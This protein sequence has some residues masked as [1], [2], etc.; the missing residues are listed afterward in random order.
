MEIKNLSSLINKLNMLQAKYSQASKGSVVVG[1]T[2]QYAIYVHENMNPVNLPGA[3]PV[4]KTGANVKNLG[5]LTK[6]QAE[7][8]GAKK[9][10]SGLGYYWG[11][12]FYGPKFLEG[13]ARALANDGTLTRIVTTAVKAG[14]TVLQAL[15][16]AGQR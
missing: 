10:A 9:R 5:R 4:H 7:A 14:A 8:G 1:Y 13:P 3:L 2:A 6:A 16:L 12:S 15:L 11:P